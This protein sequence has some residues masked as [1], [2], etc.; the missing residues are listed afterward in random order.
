MDAR[1]T[2]QHVLRVHDTSVVDMSHVVKVTVMAHINRRISAIPL[3]RMRNVCML[4]N[5]DVLIVSKLA[6]LLHFKN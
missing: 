2:I 1:L 3:E 6:M 5:F 4:C